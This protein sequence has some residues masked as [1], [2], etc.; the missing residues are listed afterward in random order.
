M[1]ILP[2]LRDGLFLG[3]ILFTGHGRW[4]LCSLI[5]HTHK[6]ANS[7]LSLATL[8]SAGRDYSLP[9]SNRFR[10][11]TVIQLHRGLVAFWRH[12]HGEQNDKSAGGTFNFPI[13]AADPD[14]SC[15][16]GE[17]GGTPGPASWRRR[18]QPNKIL[19]GWCVYGCSL[20]SASSQ[21]SPPKGEFFKEK[22]VYTSCY[23]YSS[24]LKGW[25]VSWQDTFHL[26]WAPI[27][28][29][30]CLPQTQTR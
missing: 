13:V 19:P 11:G 2:I 7:S 29:F 6:Q 28:L 30:P 23:V 15:Y 25:L 4:L 5:C 8:G 20:R 18:Q 22:Y 17:T 9:G 16:C 24:H 14:A 27:T 10:L 1:F 26:L 21:A 3:E 12:Q